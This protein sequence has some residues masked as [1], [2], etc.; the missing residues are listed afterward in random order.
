M[1]I[2]LAFNFITNKLKH[3]LIIMILFVVAITLII[4]S[5]LISFGHDYAYY[6]A[7]SVLS[8][9]VSKTGVLRLSDNN[10]EYINDLLIQ[11]EIESLGSSYKFSVDNIPEI[12]EIQ[13]QYRTSNDS[14]IDFIFVNLSCC[15]LCDIKLQSGKYPNELD[16]TVQD[17]KKIEYLYLGHAYRDIP[18]NTVYDTKS[19]KYIVAGVLDESQKWIN[20]SLLYGFDINTVDYTL[21]CSYEI[22]SI[23][24]SLPYTSDIWITA[25]DNYTIEQA[26]NKA[27]MLSKKHN[28]TTTYRTLESSYER[29]TADS[30]T[31]NSILSK[32]IVIVC[33]SCVLMMLCIQSIQIISD[34]REMGIMMSVG[35]STSDIWRSMLIKNVIIS[36]TSFIFIIPICI[37]IIKW[38]FNTNVLFNIAFSILI[39]KSL[40]IAFTSVIFVLF[41]TSI[42]VNMLLK[43]LTPHEL[44]GGIYD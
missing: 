25:S 9:G 1:A 32:L 40:P 34:K 2:K 12:Y 28:I 42:M 39:T 44:I 30:I 13:K 7:D 21:D 36:T 4:F 20:E 37:Y 15:N 5:T 31:I 43:R 24:K 41:I 16:Y 38:W 11:P 14:L 23:S 6:S 35:F 33:F 22:I 26:V 19:C 10:S 27:L 29:S 17:E 18:I 8:K 3:S